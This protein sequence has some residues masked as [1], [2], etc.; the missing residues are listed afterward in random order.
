MVIAAMDWAKPRQRS[1]TSPILDLRT[2]SQETVAKRVVRAVSEERD[3]KKA[4]LEE[5]QARERVEAQLEQATRDL[6][7]VRNQVKSEYCEVKQHLAEVELLF[8]I[9]RLSQSHKSVDET[10]QFFIEAVCKL[11]HWPVAHIY[12]TDKKHPDE[13]IS[14]IQWYLEDESKFQLFKVITENMIFKKGDGLPGQ[15]LASRKAEWLEDIYKD[16]HS[17]RAK[18]SDKLG[19]QSAFA[20]P[21]FCGTRLFALAEFW[22]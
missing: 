17:P 2:L 4:Y 5:K 10:L 22:T 18:L 20:V 16:P 19:L 13:L 11:Y 21:I 1:C 15:V 7:N 8:S 3:F 9:A 6:S 14:S 12:F